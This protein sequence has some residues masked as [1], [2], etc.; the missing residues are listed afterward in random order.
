MIIIVIVVRL[1]PLELDLGDMASSSF[2][3]DLYQRA[4]VGEDQLCDRLAVI[5]LK[6]SLDEDALNGAPAAAS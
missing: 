1:E 6:L 2:D 4:A 3:L 5:E